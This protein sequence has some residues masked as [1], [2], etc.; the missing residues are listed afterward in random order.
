M[1]EHVNKRSVKIILVELQIYKKVGMRKMK[2][3]KIIA[4][5]LIVLMFMFSAKV[6][7]SVND[8]SLV[9]KTI[10]GVFAVQ[11]YKSGGTRLY[12]AQMYEM[13]K[14]GQNLIAYCIELGAKLG[15]T[16]YSSTSSNT[17]VGLDANM[18]DYVRLFSYYGYQYENHNNYK[19][20]LAAQEL[21]WEKM[22]GDEIYWVTAEDANASRIDVEAE[23][24]EIT[25]LVNRHYVRPRFDYNTINYGDTVELTDMNKILDE[26]EITNITNGSYRLIGNNKIN[27]KADNLNSVVIEFRRKIKNNNQEMFYYA[28]NSQKIV[29]T[30]ILD[31]CFDN[32][33][34]NNDGVKIKINKKDYATGKNINQAGIAFKLYDAVSGKEICNGDKCT[35]YT[36]EYG[37]LVYEYL[38]E[39]H[40]KLVEVDENLQEYLYNPEA[41]NFQVNTATV[42]NDDT[43][44]KIVEV[45]FYNKKPTGDLTI[46]KKGEELVSDGS[47]ITYKEV[48]L[49]NVEFN[50][51]AIEDTYYNNKLVKK[52]EVLASIKTNKDGIASLDNIPL[53]KYIIKEVKTNNNYILDDKDYY[54][55]FS[56]KDQY[57][58]IIYQQLA[59]KNQLKKGKIE[60]RKI[61]SNSKQGLAGVV[62]AIYDSNN[63][64]IYEGKTDKNGNIYLENIAYGTYYIKEITPLSD[65]IKNN[66]TLE[67]SIN[68]ETKVASVIME[69][70]KLE[71]PPLTSN[72]YDYKILILIIITILNYLVI[73][74]VKD[75]L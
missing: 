59:I 26:Y 35:Y 72:V 56:Y 44:G 6:S 20:Y 57:T 1:I 39:G 38:T 32:I 63:N 37:V 55:E 61:D 58:P 60:F 12:Y 51:I 7:A 33:L 69:N 21:I 45:D 19:Y 46:N 41:V 49:E 29:S 31:D 65:Y 15:A 67:F 74:K 8:S 27:I 66:E 4:A 17:Q 13:N 70:E 75:V 9:T 10:D 50:I 68:D 23:K 71:M 53:G 64:K 11:K 16:T 34:F 40:Y 30:G 28:P 5:M 42:I 24:S 18:A 22:T 48:D 43:Y 3:L 62:I 14:N 52:G 2:K 54:V 73:N 36:N 25:R 47:S